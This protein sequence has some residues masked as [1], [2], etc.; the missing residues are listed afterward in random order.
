MHRKVNKP[1]I[2]GISNSS[3]AKT[4]LEAYCKTLIESSPIRCLNLHN[5]E[6]VLTIRLT[7]TAY[8]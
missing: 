3:A 7:S 6:K 8:G 2:S 1:N 4:R 5:R